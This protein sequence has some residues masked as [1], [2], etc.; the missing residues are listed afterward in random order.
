MKDS[1]PNSTRQRTLAFIMSPS[2]SGSTLLTLLLAEHPQIATVGELK[3][4]SMGDI[5][6]YYCS[7]GELLLACPF[8]SRVQEAM[9]KQGRKFSFDN[10]DTHFQ[11]PQNPLTNRLLKSSLRNSLFETIRDLGFLFSPTARKIKANIIEQN[12]AL[13]DIICSLQQARTFLD[14]SKDPVR[15]KFLLD[16]GLWDIRTIHLIRDGRGVTNSYMR[17]QKMPMAQAAQ[18]WLHTQKECN[19]MIRL[20]GNRRCLT[21]FYEN[22][23]HEPEKNLTSIYNFLGLEP[24]IKP[25]PSRT[26]HIMGNRMRLS[27][28][29]DICLDE[30]W[31]KTL[32]AGNLQIFAEIAGELNHSHGYK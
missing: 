28:L 32:S 2:Y 19:R 21:V 23:C 12:Q 5:S 14:G 15:L 30:K 24:E 29:K 31:K 6:T 13:I 9:L 18:E 11:Y 25:S 1:S 16:S 17:N 10:Y 20:L 7:C 4:T 8:W 3:A 22:L 27:Q 26:K